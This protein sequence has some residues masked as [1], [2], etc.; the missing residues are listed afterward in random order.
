M[1][2]KRKC[3]WYSVKFHHDISNRTD[4]YYEYITIKN[5]TKN[6]YIYYFSH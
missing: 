4:L 3:C 2:D 6:K 1:H 5:Y